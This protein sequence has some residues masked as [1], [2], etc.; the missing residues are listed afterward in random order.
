M[1]QAG[2]T[3]SGQIRS[4]LWFKNPVN[5]QY[6]P[7]ARHGQMLVILMM[8]LCLIIDVGVRVY[9]RKLIND[10]CQND[11]CDLSVSF[12][13]GICYVIIAPSATPT[14]KFLMTNNRTVHLF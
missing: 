1:F 13:K 10:K 3:L 2:H 9:F 4:S 14:S 8:I 6:C 5:L 11:F 12:A 7:D